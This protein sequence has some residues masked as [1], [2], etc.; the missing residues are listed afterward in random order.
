MDWPRWLPTLAAVTG[1]LVL[2]IKFTR[3]ARERGALSRLDTTGGSQSRAPG[4]ARW[5]EAAG[6]VL[7]SCGLA[8]V[9][10][11]PRNAPVNPAGWLPIILGLALLLGAIIWILRAIRELGRQW[12]AGSGISAASVTLITTGPYARVRHPLYLGFFGV[13]A[14]TGVMLTSWPVLPAAAGMF[15]IGTA[16][17]IRVEEAALRTHLGEAHRIYANQVPAFIPRFRRS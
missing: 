3:N 1:W 15:L 9:W 14:G 2:A 11:F 7:Q 12:R 17:R 16:L 13:L 10:F 6:G 8:G 5:T 4:Q